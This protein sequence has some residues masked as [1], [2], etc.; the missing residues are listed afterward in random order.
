MLL[1]IMVC[2]LLQGHSETRDM[3]L[4]ASF[5]HELS[6]GPGATEPSYDDGSLLTPSSTP[7]EPPPP[8]FEPPDVNCT[9]VTAQLGAEVF[10]PCRVRGLRPG[11]TVSWMRR[12][13]GGGLQLL[14]FGPHTYSA[15]ERYELSYEPRQGDW[16]LRIRAAAERD[17]GDYE[18][19]V[20]AHP[21]AVFRVRLTV[22]VP[23]VEI[24]DER[25][26]PAVQDRF[27]KEG[28]TIELKCVVSQAPAA[29]QHAGYI[30]WRH[31]AR[32]LN[33]DTSRG[34][35]SVKTDMGPGMAT[36]RL[37]IANANRRD[38]GN[39]TCALAAVA[40]TTVF[41]YV[42]SG[43]T[44]AAMQHGGAAGWWSRGPGVAGALWRLLAACLL[45]RL[46]L[47]LPLPLPMNSR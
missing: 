34:G 32:L 22:V 47:P 1:Q 29:Q 26:D 8:F 3:S 43:E 7:S 21:P 25:G 18:C 10:L 46:L 35:I 11:L 23:R 27:Y 30:T 40:S 36:S 45:P 37:Y 20:S 13:E 15:D 28:S 31:G 2:C 4:P 12:E 39:Y 24:V 14:T 33:Y 6:P 17:Q 9:A 38:S 19:Q 5:W 41:V 16:R 42:I 44:P